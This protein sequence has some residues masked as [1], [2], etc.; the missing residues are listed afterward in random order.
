MNFLREGLL[1]ANFHVFI[2]ILLIRFFSVRCCQLVNF[3]YCKSS[4]LLTCGCEDDITQYIKE[5]IKRFR[6]VVPD[7]SHLKATLHNLIDSE[8]TTV[9]SVQSCGLIVNVNVTVPASLQL[10]LSHE[11]L[12]VQTLIQFVEDQAT[13][14]SH[15]C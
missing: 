8:Q 14:C 15:Q 2:H 12:T 5:H 3:R 4:V 6:F 9:H 1:I 10:F 7:I 13:L 11:E